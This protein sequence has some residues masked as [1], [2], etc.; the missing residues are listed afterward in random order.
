M[1]EGNRS[2]QGGDVPEQLA[3]KRMKRRAFLSGLAVGA[4]TVGVAATGA[5]VVN[6]KARS[7]MT[8]KALPEGEAAQVA[9]SFADS[10]PA[11]TAYPKAKA[12]SPNVVVIMLDDCG[13]SDLGC[14]GSEIKTPAMD[15]L[16]EQGLRYT[17]FRTCSMCSPTRASF[18]TGL[19]HHSAGMGWL[20]DIDAGYPGY[21]G[22]L[23]HEAATLAE[24]LQAAGWSTFLSGKWHV[25]NAHT[26]GA[27]GPYDNWPTQRGFD[28][29]YWFQGHSTDYFKPSE[30]FDGVAP[31]EPPNDPDYFVCDDLTNRA[32]TYIRTQ[33]ALEPGRPFY[34]HLAYP[35]PHSP[36]Q[37]PAHERDAY[38]GQYDVGWDVIRAERLKRQKAL[39]LLPDTVELPPLSRGSDSWDKLPEEHRKITARYMEVYAGLMTNMDKNI[40]RLMQ[41][42]DEL[43]L[44]ENTIVVLFSDNGGS[45]EGTPTGTPNVFA[46]AFGRPVPVEEAAKFYDT[47][48]EEGTFPHYPMGW[49]SASNT[50]FKMYKQFAHLGGV[51][52]PL[53]VSWP[54]GISAKGELRNNFV[55]VVD[56]F[57]TLLQATGVERPAVYKGR[58]QKPIEG[59]SVFAT[60]EQMDA[61]TRDEQYFELGGHRAYKEGNWRAVAQ[62]TR[63]QP[64]EDDVWTLYD[65]SK[66]PAEANDLAAQFPDVVQRL[67]DKWLAAA[68]KYQVLP[69]DDRNLV[70]RLVQDRQEKGIR[71]KW[72]F[73]PPVERLARDV[74]PIVCGLSHSIEVQCERKPGAGDGVLV[75]QGAKYAGWVLYIKDGK[76]F[77]EQSLIPYIERIETS[78]A[79]PEG[80]LT[81]RYVQDMSARPFDGTGSLWVNGQQV[82]KHTFKRVLFSTSY[83]GFTVGSDLGNQVSTHYEGS[84]PFQGHISRVLIDV[85]NRPTNPVETLRF[86]NEMVLNV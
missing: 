15:N 31:V 67:K 80:P 54:K 26:T 6:N 70:L 79:L 75:A 49:A 43:G 71:A 47:L 68:Q 9:L 32:I 77:Y 46:P 35:G 38:K 14:Y 52:D 34:L 10:R 39:G 16:A 59:Q 19:N 21:R 23:T 81:I 50:P 51:A 56:L 57:P 41:S 11:S 66:D 8:P 86:L 25:N 63:G 84:N 78:Q 40:A 17:N 62:H 22:D 85:D 27:N 69:L 36:L 33:Q 48:G 4:A 58:V 29:A 18:L 1:D 60:F 30:L 28:R 44:R 7:L 2:E 37:A 5:H 13:F 24:V 12:G 76:L 72:E 42:L 73:H 65:L 82:A 61:P 55:H 74:A 53:I 20:A 83:D 64:F 45:P 3:D